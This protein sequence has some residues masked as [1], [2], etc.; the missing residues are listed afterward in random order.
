MY[1]ISDYG[2]FGKGCWDPLWGQEFLR[3]RMRE[4]KPSKSKEASI[5]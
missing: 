2:D 1:Y 4:G 3:L 5:K